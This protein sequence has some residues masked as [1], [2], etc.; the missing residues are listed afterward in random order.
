MA[1]DTLTI[2]LCVC[3]VFMAVLSSLCNGFIRRPRHKGGG[4]AQGAHGFSIVIAT[5]DNAA[6]LER[7]LPR[8]LTQDYEAGYEVI[9]VDESSTDDTED[10]LKRLKAK[11]PNLYTTFIPE[12]SHYLSRRKLAL[13]VG[14]KAAKNEWIIFTDADC[15][16]EDDNWLKAMAKYCDDNTDIAFGYTNYSHDTKG[17][18]RFERLLTYC[19]ITR[20]AVPYRY[21]GNNLAV[22]KS[23]FMDRNGFLKNLKYLRGEYDF[24]VNEYASAGRTAVVPPSETVVRQDAPSHKSWINTGLYYIETR[25]HLSRSVRFRMLPNLNTLLLHL[26]YI[27]EI[28]ALAYSLLC[29]NI[30][31]M[32]AAIAALVITLAL[33]IIIAKRTMGIFGEN[34]AGIKIP[35]FEIRIM[36]HNIRL[37]LKHRMADKYDFIRK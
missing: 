30:V 15:A 23:V 12:S 4:N 32:S 2:V 5:H 16:P 18:Y 9:V 21:N 36:W 25:K 26:N 14:V 6:A 31:V 22:R 17:F 29:H 27:I 37:M 7:N 13:T 19:Y 28:A 20:S 1:I 33:R 24:M 35:F 8:L 11:F 10:V 3:L 34:I